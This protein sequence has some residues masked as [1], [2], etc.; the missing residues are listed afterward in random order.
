MKFSK[1]TISVFVTFLICL[2]MGIDVQ[3]QDFEGVVHYKIPTSPSSQMNEIAYMI[4]DKQVRME[5]GQGQNAVAIIYQPENEE[6]IVLV[7]RMQAYMKMNKGNR[8]AGNQ[9]DNQSTEPKIEQTGKTKTIAGYSCE[10]WNVET[11]SGDTLSMCMNREL[12]KFIT[13]QNPMSNRQGPIWAQITDPGPAFPLEVKTIGDDEQVLL[14]ATKIEEKALDASLFEIPE[15]YS[16]MSGLMK[17][18]QNRN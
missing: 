15:N 18:L 13:P 12:G 10:I 2:Y 14:L 6:T 4:K 9:A 16:D 17:Q 8:G 5:M 3:A 11:E 7:N 1:L